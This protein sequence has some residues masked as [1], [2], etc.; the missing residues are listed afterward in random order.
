MPVS[1]AMI[2]IPLRTIIR[3]PPVETEGFTLRSDVHL[4]MPVS[5]GT[6][7]EMNDSTGGYNERMIDYTGK[8]TAP[9]YKGGT[10]HEPANNSTDD[11]SNLP[12][13]FNSCMNNCH[14]RSD[15]YST[16]RSGNLTKID[17]GNS[18]NQH[19]KKHADGGLGTTKAPYTDPSYNYVMA[20]TDCHEPHG[21]PNEWLLRT[22]VNGTRG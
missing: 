5:R 8:Y 22:C 9:Y 3:L 17:W 4:T 7:G 18:G 12:N 19:G 16:E 13:F 21:S 11:G 15:V 14:A 20:C 10:N 6:F 2:H 1:S